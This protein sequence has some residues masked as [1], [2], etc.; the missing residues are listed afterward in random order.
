M[1]RIYN[2]FKIDEDSYED[3]QQKEM[4]QRNFFT[5]KDMHKCIKPYA[6]LQL[7]QRRVIEQT[8]RGDDLQ[9]KYKYASFLIA[10]R[11]NHSTIR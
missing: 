10:K 9:K 1:K 2:I 5:T 7:E 11:E 4:L 8:V 3:K 6:G